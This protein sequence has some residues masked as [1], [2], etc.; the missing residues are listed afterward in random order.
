[1]KASGVR[2]KKQTKSF[3]RFLLSFVEIGRNN[4]FKNNTIYY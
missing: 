1:M 4:H 2:I 3:K